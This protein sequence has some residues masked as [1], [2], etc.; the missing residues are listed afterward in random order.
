[1][2]KRRA[3]P[4]TVMS[5]LVVSFTGGNLRGDVWGV[6]C[7]VL[8]VLPSGLGA[9]GDDRTVRRASVPSPP[10]LIASRRPRRTPS[11]VDIRRVRRATDDVGPDGDLRLDSIP[12]WH[13]LE[14]APS[15]RRPPRLRRSRPRPRPPRRARTAPA[16]RRT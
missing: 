8:T 3:T 10:T 9:S 11:P 6:T 12:S 5:L 15:R 13:P 1:M 14:R 16:S 7:L 4:A 2:P